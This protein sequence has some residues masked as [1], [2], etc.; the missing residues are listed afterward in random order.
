MHHDMTLWAKD[1]VDIRR[2]HHLQH[3]LLGTSMYQDLQWR[4]SNPPR[5]VFPAYPSRACDPS[6]SAQSKSLWENI[7]ILSVNEGFVIIVVHQSNSEI[8]KKKVVWQ[9]IT[10]NPYYCR[11]PVLIATLEY[12]ILTSHFNLIM[13]GESRKI[14]RFGV[15]THLL[16][17]FI[18]GISKVLHQKV[19][20]HLIQV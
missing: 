11:L 20:L 16:V 1:W 3:Q 7:S 10:H 13:L 5:C 18:H 4:I 14:C 19:A 9:P 15:W 8:L 17:D 12:Q 2:L 6:F